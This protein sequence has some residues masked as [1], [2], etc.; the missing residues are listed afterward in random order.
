MQ[1]IFLF[2]TGLIL[3]FSFSQWCCAAGMASANFQI[4]TSVFSGGVSPMASE[5]FKNN[6]TLGQPSPIMDP[7]D[8]PWSSAYDLYPGFWY[9]LEAGTGCDNLAAFAAAF[10]HVSGD[11]GYCPVCDSEP[12]GDVDGEDLA[13]YAESF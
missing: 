13:Q 3:V 5:N 1:K 12:D 9:T 11:A 8:P 10:G 6:S 7:E 4:T 2:C